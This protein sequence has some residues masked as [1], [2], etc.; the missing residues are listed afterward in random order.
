MVDN[1]EVVQW[2]Y[3]DETTR[4]IRKS[5]GSDT[6]TRDYMSPTEKLKPQDVIYR[7]YIRFRGW[8]SSVLHR[9]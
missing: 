4:M 7:W 3:D 2:T 6:C 9:N 8:I 1:D 5:V